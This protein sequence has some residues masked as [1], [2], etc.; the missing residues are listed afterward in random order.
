[1]SVTSGVRTT[2]LVA[3]LLLGA[4]NDGGDPDATP[5]PSRSAASGP[6]APGGTVP[7]PSRLPPPARVSEAMAG[8]DTGV[9]SSEIRLA[10][11]RIN[12]G[13]QYRISD[14]SAG[15]ATSGSG[16]G[17]ERLEVRTI[18]VDDLVHTQVARSYALC[19]WRYEAGRVDAMSADLRGVAAG[20][21]FA[22]STQGGVPAEVATVLDL[23]RDG[24]G[25][26]AD[27]RTVVATLGSTLSRSFEVPPG[28]T[29]RTPVELRFNDAGVLTGWT[30][31]FADIVASA[32]RGGHASL[33]EVE[34]TIEVWFSKLG[35]PTTIAVPDPDRLVALTPRTVDTAVDRI[36]AC[37]LR[38]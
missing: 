30:T 16:P 8:L 24:D 7:A 2:A 28:S 32:R 4:C 15:Y 29:T 38:R 26:S 19:F 34:G 11:V 13:G 10:D 5:P 33:G 25:A 31:T 17:F 9:F 22:A 23:R 37:E 36:R 1:M 6:A 18:A 35:Q 27:L 12:R 14:R 3:V 20:V 21:D